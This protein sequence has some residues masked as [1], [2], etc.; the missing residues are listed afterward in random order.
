MLFDCSVED[1]E[2]ERVRGK[3]ECCSIVC[4]VGSHLVSP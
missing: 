2:A 3:C 4:G 1:V